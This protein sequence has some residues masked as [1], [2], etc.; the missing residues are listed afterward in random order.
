MGSRHGD[1]HRRLTQQHTTV[2]MPQH[3]PT[4]VGPGLSCPLSESL[5]SADDLLLERLVINV[6][7]V[8][9]TLGVVP[10]QT[11]EDDDRPAIGLTLPLGRDLYIESMLGESDPGLDVGRRDRHGVMVVGGELPDAWHPTSVV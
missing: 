1:D 4:E 6:G 11:T 10:D 8:G 2:A 9:D 7:D 5:E 3:D